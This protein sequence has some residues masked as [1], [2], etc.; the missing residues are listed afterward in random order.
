M[1]TLTRK[2][3]L[4]LILPT[5]VTMFSAMAALQAGEITMTAYNWPTFFYEHDVYDSAEKT[6]GLFRNHI[7]VRVRLRLLRHH[8]FIVKSP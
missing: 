3:F 1:R 6:N 4:L 2:H 7:V 5:D 8:L